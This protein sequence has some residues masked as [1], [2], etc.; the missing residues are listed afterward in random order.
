MQFGVCNR[1]IAWLDATFTSSHIS[2]VDFH[3]ILVNDA[4]VVYLVTC[5]AVVIITFGFVHLARF[6]FVLHCL[7]ETICEAYSTS[8]PETD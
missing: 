8:C 7:P 3:F 2:P 5:L 6:H 4:V 1:L